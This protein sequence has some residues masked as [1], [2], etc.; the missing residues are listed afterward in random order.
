MRV[1]AIASHKGG[2]GKTT[3]TLN[4][5]CALAQRGLRVLVID[6]DP[7]GGIGSSLAQSKR[8]RPGLAERIAWKAPDSMLVV[9]TRLPGLRLLPV[10][11]VPISD[12]MGFSDQLADGAALR[13]VLNTTAVG[14]DIVLIDTPAGFGGATLGA[15]RVATH[16]L[17]PLHAEPLA[18]RTAP[19]TFEVL[20]N[21]REIGCS[22]A[23]AGFVLSMVQPRER[24]SL[25]VIESAYRDLP[26][27][28]VRSTLIPRDPDFLEASA[29][30]VPVGLLSKRAPAVAAVFDQLAAELEPLLGIG[31]VETDDGPPSFLP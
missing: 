15:M 3:I 25:A 22:P 30:G 1:L 16:L 23:F 19:Q 18:L 28:T 27:G 24:A 11:N 20:A 6:T 14:D 10:G 7:Q 8:A 4:L 21:L 5:A 17:S 29:A 9:R 13:D 26:P 12:T 31:P 2:V